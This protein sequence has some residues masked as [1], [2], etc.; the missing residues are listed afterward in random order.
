MTGNKYMASGNNAEQSKAQNSENTGRY[1]THKFVNFLSDVAQHLNV[2]KLSIAEQLVKDVED[3]KRK[4]A[5]NNELKAKENNAI[6]ELLQRLQTKRRRVETGHG[7]GDKVNAKGA[8][9]G[10]FRIRRKQPTVIKY[11]WNKGISVLKETR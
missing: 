6:N 7:I 10:S 4:K 8:G 9:V 1:I 5:Q 11:I 2:D 3:S